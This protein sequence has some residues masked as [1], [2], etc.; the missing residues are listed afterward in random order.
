MVY[1]PNDDEDPTADD[2]NYNF[3]QVAVAFLMGVIMMFL[4]NLNEIQK[5]K[6]CNYESR[7]YWI[8]KNG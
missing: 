2:C 6:V 3:P 1:N 8:G 4:L 7:N 5:F